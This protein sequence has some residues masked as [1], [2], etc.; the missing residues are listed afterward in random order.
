MNTRKLLI[1]MTLII[2]VILSLL[3]LFA[4]VLSVA[5][6]LEN[7]KSI[8]KIRISYE[9][10]R[11]I[12]ISCGILIPFSL[13]LITFLVSG[14]CNGFILAGIVYYYYY[15]IAESIKRNYREYAENGFS[16]MKTMESKESRKTVI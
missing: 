12:T 15:D 13:G 14:S 1:G 9:D 5:S 11:L 2:G 10:I 8:F 7:M 16:I 3:A 4:F 6:F